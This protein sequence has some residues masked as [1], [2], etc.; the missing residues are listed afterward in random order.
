MARHGGRNGFEAVWIPERHFHTMGRIY[1]NP[2][3]PAAYP[4]SITTKIRL[5]AG[6]I[7]ETCKART[8]PPIRAKSV[9]HVSGTNRNPC[10]RNGPREDGA[11][12]GIDQVI[13]LF[14]FIEQNSVRITLEY[15]RNYPIQI[16][17]GGSIPF[18]T[19]NC[20]V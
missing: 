20:P 4:A 15:P 14:E 12:G 8:T 6:S 18:S 3:V 13:D 5:Q 2:A 10:V 1:P 7:D 17:T 16:H 9:T 11:R 19:G